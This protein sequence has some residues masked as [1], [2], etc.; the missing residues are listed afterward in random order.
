VDFFQLV[1]GS[2]VQHNVSVEIIYDR[3]K[4]LG[5]WSGLLDD[6]IGGRG[7]YANDW[8]LSRVKHHCASN[9]TRTNH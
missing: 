6:S 2:D 1:R 8:P 5:F 4:H 7:F 3:E 9:Q